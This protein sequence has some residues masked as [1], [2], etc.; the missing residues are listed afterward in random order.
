MVMLREGNPGI[1]Q[2]PLEINYQQS[3]SFEVSSASRVVKFVLKSK[4]TLQKSCLDFKFIA[5]VFSL[6]TGIL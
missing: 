6:L 4:I 2:A 1:P 3:F 5:T